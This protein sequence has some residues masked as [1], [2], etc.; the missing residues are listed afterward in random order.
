MVPAPDGE[1]FCRLRGDALRGIVAFRRETLTLQVLDRFQNC[2][3][4]TFAQSVRHLISTQEGV[5][6]A[7]SNSGGG[8]ADLFLISPAALSP[9]NVPECFILTLC[10]T[11]AQ[12][13]GIC[14]TLLNEASQG[15]ALTF[16]QARVSAITRVAGGDVVAAELTGP[17]KS[18]ITASVADRGRGVYTLVFTVNLA[19]TWSLLPSVRLL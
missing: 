1:A 17:D 15:S 7:C 4:V 19:G 2:R 9:A 5:R 16:V 3:R 14:S 10:W 18:V 12:A 11:V 13:G 8:T 6:G